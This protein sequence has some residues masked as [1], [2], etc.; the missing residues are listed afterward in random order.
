MSHGSVLQSLSEKSIVSFLSSIDGEKILVLEKSMVGLFDM[1]IKYSQLEKVGVIKIIEWNISLSDEPLHDSATLIY[2]MRSLCVDTLPL[3]TNLGSWVK[4]NQRRTR[5]LVHCP[6]VCKLSCGRLEALGIDFSKDLP[7]LS[8]PDLQ[9]VSLEEDTICLQLSNVFA[10]YHARSDPTSLVHVSKFLKSLEEQFGVGL[11]HVGKKKRKFRRI[12]AIG[13][14]AKWVADDFLRIS[15]ESN[16]VDEPNQ[17]CDQDMM[18]GIGRVGGL[19]SISGLIKDEVLEEEELSISP[20]L[21]I[22]SIVLIDRRSDPFSVLCSQFTYEALIDELFGI[23][24][25]KVRFDDPEGASINMSLTRS[26]DPLFGEVRDVHVSEIGSVL[27]K[28]ANLISA[29][30]K[31]KDSL[32]SISEIGDFMEKFKSV[33]T[34][35]SSLAN[36]VALA[37]RVTRVTNDVQ[38]SWIL[39]LEDEI[40]SMGKVGKILE[41]IDSMIRRP[42]ALFSLERIVRL[43]CLV[44]V[45]YGPK[46]MEKV[47]KSLVNKFGMKAIQILAG[48]QLSGL[49]GFNDTGGGLADLMSSSATKWGK[50]REE[51][52]LILDPNVLTP[53]APLADAYSG[54]VPLSVR[55]VQL[56]NTSW[57]SSAAS[58]NLVRGPALEIAQE[59]PVATNGTGVNPNAS[60]VA[61]VFIGGVT[62]G[63]IAAFRKLSQLEGGRRKFLIIT[64]EIT[65]YAKLIN[66][67]GH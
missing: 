6:F 12:N 54:Y 33:Q 1:N 57:K 61:V 11:G 10:E 13:T 51:F 15:R 8:I 35:H 56:L 65:N 47:L 53:D 50:L 32:N 63:E 18:R 60:F 31:E 48:L 36:H 45:V 5:Y 67:L 9:S 14:A 66:S 38:Y 43:I 7:V 46:S 34:Q 17:S 52:K 29:S 62:R 37:T 2:M 3:S 41:K 55:L 42:D 28:K 22:D 19:S 39:K 64:T 25:T 49:L 59:C 40:M 4:Q 16:S 44:S 24:N 26:G 23:H 58:L 30:Y 20:E 27:S 21:A